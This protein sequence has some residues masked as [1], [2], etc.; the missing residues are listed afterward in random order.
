MAETNWEKNRKR[1]GDHMKTLLLQIVGD[2]LC[3][4]ICAL[5]T[6]P[7]LISHLKLG[8]SKGKLER[9]I[10]A[11]PCVVSQAIVLVHIP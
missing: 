8:L 3:Y 7:T 2:V 6:N 5:H 10:G 1:S 11:S 9:D 4:R